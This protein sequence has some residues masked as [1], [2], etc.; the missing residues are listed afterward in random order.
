M[1]DT[2]THVYV[3]GVPDTISIV[4]RSPNWLWYR[5]LDVIQY[6]IQYCTTDT[7]TDMVEISEILQYTYSKLNKISE[8]RNDMMII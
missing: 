5:K 4:K 3:K 8:T 1:Y 2:G 6:N 7:G